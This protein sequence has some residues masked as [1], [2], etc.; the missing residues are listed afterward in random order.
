M[1]EINL[2]EAIGKQVGTRK[3]KDIVKYGLDLQTNLSEF[4]KIRCKRGVYK[5]K[6]F[7]EADQWMIDHTILITQD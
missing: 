3:V 1:Y 2:E 6:T 5:F 7:E 4:H